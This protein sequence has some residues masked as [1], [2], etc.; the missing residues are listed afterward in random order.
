MTDT[1]FH[2]DFHLLVR[3]RA[4]CGKVTI[5]TARPPC[6]QVLELTAAVILAEGRGS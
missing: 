2:Y 3:T 4:F 1:C 6:L 5:G